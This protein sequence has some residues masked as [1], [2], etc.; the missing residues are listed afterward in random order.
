MGIDLQ[1]FVYVNDTESRS[2]CRECDGPEQI[3][4]MR[5]GNKTTEDKSLQDGFEKNLKKMLTKK[6]IYS[7]IYTAPEGKNW[8]CICGCKKEDATVIPTEPPVTRS[9][10]LGPLDEPTGS[11]TVVYWIIAAIIAV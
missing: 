1:F 7:E 4:L 11:S 2:P 6:R 9:P 3:K 10:T 5:V 8:T